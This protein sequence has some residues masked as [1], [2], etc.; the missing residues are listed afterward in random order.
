LVSDI[1]KKTEL[2]P[3]LNSVDFKRF[4]QTKCQFDETGTYFGNL[5]FFFWWLLPL[6]AMFCLAHNPHCCHCKSCM[7]RKT[8][9]TF[10][11]IR[12]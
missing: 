6:P 1:D 8:V 12:R 7:W 9:L 11:K 2:G 4:S 10:G 5:P 3:G